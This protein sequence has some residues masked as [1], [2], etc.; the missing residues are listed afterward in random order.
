MIDKCANPQCDQRLVYLRSGLLYAVERPRAAAEATTAT[1]HFWLCTT[2]S[3]Q[4]RLDFK[5]RD[6]PDFVSVTTP[7]PPYDSDVERRVRCILIRQTTREAAELV[8]P[9]ETEAKFSAFA[10]V[11]RGPREPR[12]FHADPHVE[13]RTCA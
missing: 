5:G 7:R 11:G 13:E 9:E 12:R 6:D 1:S 8:G 4:Y 2:C 3:H 10:S